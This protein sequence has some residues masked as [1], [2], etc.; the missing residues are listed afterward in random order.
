MAGQVTHR[1][2]KYLTLYSPKTIFRSHM[3]IFSA[4]MSLVASRETK[5]N[6]YMNFST[7]LE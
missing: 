5:I 2:A 6:F 4:N 7:H 3:L 1:L